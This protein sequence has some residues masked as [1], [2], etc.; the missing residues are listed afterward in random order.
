MRITIETNAQQVE[1]YLTD[2]Q[3]WD[4]PTAR[5]TLRAGVRGV[6]DERLALTSSALTEKQ[7]RRLKRIAPW[8]MRLP[9]LAGFLW[10]WVSL[11]AKWDWGK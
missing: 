10:A 5:W 7:V 3:Q 2:K 4:R 1:V 9:F 6:V 8:M 11:P